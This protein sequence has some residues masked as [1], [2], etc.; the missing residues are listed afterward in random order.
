[1]LRPRPGA[2]AASRKVVPGSDPPKGETIDELADRTTRPRGRRRRAGPVARARSRRGPRGGAARARPGGGTAHRHQAQPQRRRHPGR[3]RHRGP[4]RRAPGPHGP[5][6]AG[7][8]GAR[9]RLLARSRLGARPDRRHA[10]LCGGP[11][12]LGDLAGSRRGRGSGAR[13]RGRSGGRPPLHGRGR[14]GR[15]CGSAPR[16]GYRRRSA[17]AAHR[18]H[19]SDRRR[20]HRPPP[21]PGL[22]AAPARDHSILPGHALLRSGGA[23]ARRGGRGTSG[24]PGPPLAAAMGRRRRH[25]D[26]SG[27][28]RG[29]DPSG[30]DATGR[31]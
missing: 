14:T 31:A 23:G 15:P 21:R 28:G 20:R 1:M 29:G 26:L 27:G 8:G 13:D 11:P 9:G 12:P 16:G 4:H 2:A 3:S 22:P 10:E 5:P 18:G 19:P 17:A 7:G 6:A 25:A 24:V 30:R